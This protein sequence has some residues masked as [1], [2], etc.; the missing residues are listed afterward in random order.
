MK[1][2]I[3]EMCE[4]TSFIKEGDFFVCQACGMNTPPRS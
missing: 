1:Q 3:C 2:P 4:G